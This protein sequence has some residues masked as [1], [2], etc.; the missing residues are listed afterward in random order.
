VLPI[1]EAGGRHVL[2]EDPN[3]AAILETIEREGVTTMYAPPTMLYGMLGAVRD[4][5]RFPSLRH[6]IYSAAPMTPERIRECQRVFGPVI[7]TAYG[8]VEAPQIISAM[9]AHELLLDVNLASVGRP[10]RVATVRI[11]GGSG[12]SA[13]PGE[14]GEILVS[15]PL[16]MN[17][18]LDQPEATNATIVNGWLHTGD[19]GT[20]DARG[21]LFIRGRIKET[22]NT[23]G[24]KVHPGEVEA[25]LARHPGVSECAVFGVSD[26]KWGEAV[27]A[28]VVR[29]PGTTTTDAQ[30]IDWVK[31]QLGSV[32][33]PKSIRFLLELPRNAA[34][35]V[36][37]AELRGM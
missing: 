16:L 15:G 7:E 11:D 12:T 8:Q 17:G 30:L 5:Q 28:A 20:I 18:Y 36:S 10:S 19:T 21:Y 34:G 37:R 13:Q 9:R 2:L 26:E 25:V 24:F 4:G 29:A 3:P 14:V 35:K 27:T 32:K 33:A 6:V 23:G 22:I 1:F 31:Q